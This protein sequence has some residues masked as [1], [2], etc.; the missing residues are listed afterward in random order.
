MI[1]HGIEMYGNSIKCPQKGHMMI[2][3][4][5]TSEKVKEWDVGRGFRY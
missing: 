3:D 2:P 5:S 1:M 4:Y